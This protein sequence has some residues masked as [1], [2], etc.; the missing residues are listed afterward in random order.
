MSELRILGRDT[1]VRI[2]EDNELVDAFTAAQSWSFVVN[3]KRLE[4]HYIGASAVS[5]D[6]IYES[7]SGSTPFH[8]QGLA[9]IKMQKRIADRAM[10]RSNP[11]PIY[12]LNFRIVVPNGGVARITVPDIKFGDIPLKAPNREGYVD[13]SLDWKA[14]MYQLSL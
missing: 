2:V 12:S 1:T 9:A 6:E 3:I 11:Q 4:E 13:M 7:V 8:L 5:L 14:S 10:K